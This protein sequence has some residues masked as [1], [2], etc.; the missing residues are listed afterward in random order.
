MKPTI[1]I[2]FVDFY[3]NTVPE[4]T[5][6]YHLLARHFDVCFCDKPDYVIAQ[7]QGIR[8]I[9]YGRDVIKILFIAENAAPDF[10]Q[11][12]YVAGC[13]DLTFGDRYVRFPFFTCCQGFSDLLSRHMAS[14]DALLNRKFCSFVVS[15]AN[16][17][18][19][20]R[21]KF[22]RRLSQY[23][24]VDSGG[25]YLNNVGGPVKDKLDFCRGYKFNIA[26]ENSV[27]P[28]YTTEKIMHAYAA[29]SVPIYFGNPTIETDFRPESMVRV[30]DEA[31]IER[32]VE[33]I[34]RLDQDDD[35]YL[36]K[37]HE[38]CFAVPDPTIYERDLEAFLIHIFDQPLEQARRRAQYGHQ[39]MMREHMRKVFTFDQWLCNIR[40]RMHF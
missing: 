30:R 40:S 2:K 34:I 6:Y 3:K 37:C 15:N 23:K 4:R 28:G 22:F 17:A 21:E 29:D 26:F 16:F 32:A 18:D 9:S 13:D 35:A 14:D 7:G 20:I 39:A 1:R 12:D 11:F 24:R 36:A 10:N 19:P 27:Y 33:E 5:Y 38:R 8:H 31:D 25:Q